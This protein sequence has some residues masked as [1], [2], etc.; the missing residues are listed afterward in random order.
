ME[1]TQKLLRIVVGLTEKQ[2]QDATCPE[3]E[4]EDVTH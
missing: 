1:I 4:P 2:A 3:P